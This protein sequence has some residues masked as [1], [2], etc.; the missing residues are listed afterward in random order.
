[1]KKSYSNILELL[2]KGAE[3]IIYSKD[4]RYSEISQ[5][6]CAASNNDTKLHIVVGDN[7]NAAEVDCIA[8]TAKE[9]AVFDFSR[10]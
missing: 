8:M 2:R 9:H 5:L 6:A 7:L 10:D 1:M 3:A 4:F